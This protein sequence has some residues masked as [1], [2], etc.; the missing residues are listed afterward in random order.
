MCIR[1]RYSTFL[2][3]SAHDSGWGIA[4][5]SEGAAYIVGETS[6]SNF[7]VTNPLQPANAG[8]NDVFVTKLNPAGNGMTYSTYLGGNSY[9][10]GF[11]IALDFAGNVYVTGRTYSPNFPVTNTLQS[12]IVGQDDAFVA[13]LTP[14]GSAL[15]YSTYLGG[16]DRDLPYRIAVDNACNAAITLSLIHI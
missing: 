11:G 12:M 15:T 1:D 3:G 10:N 2:G 6:S 5:D 14:D 16:S 7:P 9:D 13:R 4:V 8:A